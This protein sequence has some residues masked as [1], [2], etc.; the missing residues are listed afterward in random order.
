LAG[1][2][3]ESPTLAS[4]TMPES[5]DV[6]DLVSY[7][8]PSRATVGIDQMS[9]VPMMEPVSVAIKKDYSMVMVPVYSYDYIAQQNNGRMNAQVAVRFKNN[10]ASN[11]GV[12][13]PSGAV[14][15]Y[16]SDAEQGAYVGAA[17]I[18]DTPKDGSVFLTL[19]KVFNVYGEPKVLST[20]K[21]NKHLVRKTM[22][23]T[24]H[25]QKKEAVNVRVLQ[26]FDYAM[27]PIS[28]GDIGKKIDASTMQWTVP[29]P[30]GGTKVLTYT[31]DMKV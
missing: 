6:G 9:R 1:T 2:N 13:L 24:L 23:L 4:P 8:A 17:T 12:P 3:A 10:K 18:S 16:G 21:I 31:I 15:V 11:L 7:P 29:V 27:P 25:N 30:A 19:S 5:V 20:A 22:Q 28:K 26:G 14:R